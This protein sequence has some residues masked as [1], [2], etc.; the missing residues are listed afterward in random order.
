MNAI[1]PSRPLSVSRLLYQAARFT[2]AILF[3]VWA[4]LVAAEFVANHFMLPAPNTFL[5]GMALAI[6]FFGYYLS[7]RHP[8]RGSY[9]TIVGVGLFFVIVKA[10]T[11]LW[12]PVAAGGLVLPAV[13]V[14]AAVSYRRYLRHNIGRK[15]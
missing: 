11:G 3:G 4:V 7:L 9:L 12:P 8:L 14:L 1:V 2:A 15:N 6:V 13:L 5:Q 10:T